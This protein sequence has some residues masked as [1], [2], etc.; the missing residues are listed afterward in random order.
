MPNL[1]TIIKDAMGSDDITYYFP[2]AKI[3]QYKELRKYKS[4]AHLLPKKPDFA[5]I[6][7]E[8][9][10]Q[11]G[12][13]T[14]LTRDSNNNINY[15]DS[16]GGKPDHPLT[17][18]STTDRIK[19]D[20]NVCY[21]SH[22]LNSTPEQVYYNDEDY[23]KNGM[24]VATCGRHACFYVMNMLQYHMSLQD[25]HTFMNKMKKKHKMSYDEVVSS[26]IDKM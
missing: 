5:F 21:L 1:K 10:P 3:Y 9:S 4:I 26:F 22:L 15:F 14:V 24:D 25:Y 17:W 19:L 20:Q 23:Q 11:S 7:Y 16:Y 8:D 13:W 2:H 12:H 6:L 18:Y